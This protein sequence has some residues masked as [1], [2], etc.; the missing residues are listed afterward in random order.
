MEQ[1]NLPKGKGVMIYPRYVHTTDFE[2]DKEG[3]LPVG[4]LYASQL[5]EQSGSKVDFYDGQIH[6]LEKITTGYDFYGLSVM[7][8]QNIAAAHRDYK[9]LTGKGIEP[10]KIVLGGQGL[11]SLTQGEFNKV[12]PGSNQVKAVDMIDENYWETDI[13]EQL[14]KISEED[15]QLYLQNEITV[16][17]SDG[18]KFGCGFCGAR[19]KRKEKFYSSSNYE[20]VLK[21]ANKLGIKDLSGYVTSLDFFQQSLNGGD[22]EQLKDQLRDTIRLNEKYDVNISLRALVRADSY[23][24]ATKDEGLIALTKEAGFT[25]FGFGADGIADVN[26][27]K[28]IR[29][30]NLEMKSHLINS[31][32]HAERNGFTPEILY[33]FGTGA[34]TPETLEKTKELCEELQRTFSTSIYR[35]FPAKDCIPGNLNWKS[36]IWKN[37]DA[38][39]GLFENPNKFINLGFE[40]LANETSHENESMRKQVN[41]VAVDMSLFAHRLGRVHSYLTIP[42]IKGDGR[43]LMD[44]E[45]FDKFK[46]IAEN[47]LPKATLDKITLENLGS[48]R[49]EINAAIPRDI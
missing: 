48:Y 38:Y 26:L 24:A 3:V 39:R 15:M 4:T 37:S 21:Q 47:Y 46:E 33:V 17:W 27:L 30:G 41:K 29:K 7:G 25:T 1:N 22:S 2:R 18:C 42:E 31:F 44:R 16:P 35:G 14:E 5:L 8:T 9:I 12:F 45:T 10:E 19:I 23:M 20:A 32:G 49:G 40:T 43:E 36:E 6:N 11:E 34:D 28:R 13:S